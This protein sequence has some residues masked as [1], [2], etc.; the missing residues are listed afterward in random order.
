MRR[1]KCLWILAWMAVFPDVGH[2]DPPDP[3][4]PEPLKQVSLLRH[5][6]L[7]Q[8]Q[9]LLGRP[10]LDAVRYRKGSQTNLLSPDHALGDAR[11]VLQESLSTTSYHGL[12]TMHYT[13]VSDTVK[14]TIDV[15]S[16]GT[17]TIESQ[18]WISGEW[19]RVWLTQPMNQPLQLAC[20]SSLP[21]LK[22]QAP[23]WL[24]LREADRVVFDNH[25][26]PII[27]QMIAPHCFKQ[28]AE[29]AYSHAVQHEAEAMIEQPR[30]DELIA[31]LGSTQRHD[32]MLAYR[33]LASLGLGVL[34]LL[35]K[36]D[37]SRLDAEQRARVLLLRRSLR[38][39]GEDSP[40]RL[41]VLLRHDS[42]YWKLA[43]ARMTDDERILVATRFH[44]AGMSPP[45]PLETDLTRVATVARD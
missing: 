11:S 24:H 40:E 16:S 14:V 37:L 43:G 23:T 8:F 9:L 10:Q 44:A 28:I 33:E 20:Q 26:L 21:E 29:S 12:P 4:P 13:L 5:N 25:L 45:L 3:S 35:D 15:A 30:F 18:R 32:R 17:W 6:P 2:T 39:C 41:A 19:Q 38:P 1:L 34:P 36:L 7:A 42:S 22:L 27:E 31:Y